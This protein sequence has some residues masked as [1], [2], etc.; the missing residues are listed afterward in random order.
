MA[1]QGTQPADLKKLS[2]HIKPFLEVSPAILLPIRLTG[3][4]LVLR[5][6]CDPVVA[7]SCR[8]TRMM[9]WRSM[10]GTDSGWRS[11]GSGGSSFWRG[12]QREHE[13]GSA[14]SCAC[15]CCCTGQA[16]PSTACPSAR[17]YSGRTGASRPST[18]STRASRAT[19]TR[20]REQ[21]VFAPCSL[22]R[23]KR[24]SPPFSPPCCL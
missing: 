23:T 4:R 17:T 24:L 20:V 19:R 11:R 1:S 10:T 18:T 9:A 6:T 16:V 5:L 12:R 15:L 22:S 14:V 13:E 7:S 21:S 3:M 8:C 2:K